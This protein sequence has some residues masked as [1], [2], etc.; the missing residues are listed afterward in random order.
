M[1]NIAVNYQGRDLAGHSRNYGK[2]INTKQDFINLMEVAKE[3]QLEIASDV[4]SG[5]I[6]TE[7][8]KNWVTVGDGV[9]GA[10]E[11]SVKYLG[12]IEYLREMQ[13]DKI[14]LSIY[15]AIEKKSIMVSGNYKYSNVVFLDGRLIATSRTSLNYWLESRLPKLNLNLVKAFRFVNVAAYARALETAGASSGQVSPKRKE[16]SYGR[17][18]GGQVRFTAKLPNGTY[19]LA[20][21][22]I[23]RV[24]NAE[25]IKSV[26][27]DWIQN[28]KFGA[29]LVTNSGNSRRTTFTSD[30]RP[31]LH[32]SIILEINGTASKGLLQ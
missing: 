16:V 2:E 17:K 29:N 11:A 6:G 18:R 12:T 5:D 21:N 24:T 7:Y 14:L 8:T 20:Y 19:W 23:Q 9:A 10:R 26:K 28:S 31:Y 27:F 22:S 32:P 13:I 3:R 25:T 1:L 30:G 4:R 15:D